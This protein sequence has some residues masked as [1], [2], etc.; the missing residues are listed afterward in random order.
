MKFFQ[1]LIALLLLVT[2]T[3]ACLVLQ[4]V[5]TV[6]GAHPGQIS[7][8]LTDNGIQTCKFSGIIDQD[9]YFANCNSGFASYIH[10]DLTKLAYS[11]HGHE[12]VID[13]KATRD[14]NLFET[15]DRLSARAFC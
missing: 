6:H 7:G 9:H 1:P 14:F 8:T 13:V 15:Y 4:G 2:L 11:N 3:H 5:Y 10:R 12:Y